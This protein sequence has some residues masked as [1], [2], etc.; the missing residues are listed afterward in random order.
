MHTSIPILIC[1]YIPDMIISNNSTIII[2]NALTTRRYISIGTDYTNNSIRNKL[3]FILQVAYWDIFSNR[4][5]QLRI[6][7]VIRVISLYEKLRIQNAEKIIIC[8]NIIYIIMRR[9]R[10]THCKQKSLIWIFFYFFIFILFFNFEW[11]Y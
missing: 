5:L 6:L 7:S 8:A 3:H 9:L 11:F 4:F 1:I 2:D 10:R